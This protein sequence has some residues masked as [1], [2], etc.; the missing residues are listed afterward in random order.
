M[1]RGTRLSAAALIPR[2]RAQEI[3]SNNVANLST[4]G[5]RRERLAFHSELAQAGGL[6]WPE[7]TV[8]TRPDDSVAT[9]TSTGNPLDLAIDGPGYFVVQKDGQERY[10]RAGSFRLMPDGTLA[11]AG[12]YAVMGEG[13]PLNLPA[14]EVSVADDGTMRISG[15]AVGAVRIAS[16]E[17]DALV[18]EGENLF[19]LAEGRATTP[20]DPNATVRQGHVETSNV[21]PVIELVEMLRVFREYESNH[22]AMTTAGSTLQ[23]LINEQLG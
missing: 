23:K 12:G 5:Y 17:A 15:Q 13:G 16:V 4:D 8:A 20:R 2:M 22:E 14:G 6:P 3:I 21:E 18:R 1:L 19:S 11:T 10:T 9:L 7:Q